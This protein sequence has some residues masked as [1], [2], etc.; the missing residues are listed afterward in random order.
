M[1]LKQCIRVL[2]CHT[3]TSVPHDEG[4]AFT[5]Q[6][7]LRCQRVTEFFLELQHWSEVGAGSDSLDLSPIEHT[8]E[9]LLKQIEGNIPTS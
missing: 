4:E 7:N 5:Q 3:H 2:S 9:V 6:N 8:W 1:K